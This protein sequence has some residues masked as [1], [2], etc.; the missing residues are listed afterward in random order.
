MKMLCTPDKE[1]I[2]RRNKF[3]EKKADL[4]LGAAIRNKK[5]RRI[6]H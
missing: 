4:F 6:Y 3:T 2:L 5:Q 1:T